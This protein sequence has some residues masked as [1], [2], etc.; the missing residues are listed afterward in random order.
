[1]KNPSFVDEYIKDQ[2]HKIWT[3]IYLS[4][5]ADENNEEE[6]KFLLRQM[7]ILRRSL[8][9]NYKFLYLQKSVLKKKLLIIYQFLNTK[10][11]SEMQN[12]VV[13][14]CGSGPTVSMPW[15]DL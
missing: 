7:N 5:S 6:Q 8:Y 9:N 2:V 3:K 13:S 1:M 14:L 12:R 10:K 4:S 15:T 11:N